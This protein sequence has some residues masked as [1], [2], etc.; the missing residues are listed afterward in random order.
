MRVW[1]HF[2]FQL[3]RPLYLS[4][5]LLV[6]ILHNIIYTN[7]IQNLQSSTEWLKN[8][9]TIITSEMRVN[10]G[11]VNR[12]QSLRVI[13]NMMSIILIILK[14]MIMYSKA[15]LRNNETQLQFSFLL[16]YFSDFF[17]VIAAMIQL[18]QNY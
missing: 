4:S 14:K 13:Y 5:V 8:H 12:C 16:K 18:V 15:D 9:S 1:R 10:Q 2:F 3:I 17:H 7:Y 11:R 6:R